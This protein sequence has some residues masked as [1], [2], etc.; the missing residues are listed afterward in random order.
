MADFTL[1]KGQGLSKRLIN[2]KNNKRNSKK[3]IEFAIKNTNLRGLEL[4]KAF[5]KTAP[6]VS[7][8]QLTGKWFINNRYNKKRIDIEYICS[9]GNTL[10]APFMD[11]IRGD[12]KNKCTCKIPGKKDLSIIKNEYFSNLMKTKYKDVYKSIKFNG[13]YLPIDKLTNTIKEIVSSNETSNI[14]LVAPTGA[15]KTY[16]ILNG[17]TELFKILMILPNTM[18]VKQTENTYNNLEIQGLYGDSDYHNGYSSV[19]STPDSI[20]KISNF[21]SF[22]IVFFDETHI[23]AGDYDYRPGA[24]FNAYLKTDSIKHKV[25]VTA[26]P[27][28][29]LYLK[30]FTHIIEFTPLTPKQVQPTINIYDKAMNKDNN[31]IY[32][33]QKEII[34]EINR[35]Y[36]ENK[37]NILGKEHNK[38]IILDMLY[39]NTD[40][41]INNIDVPDNQKSK[42]KSGLKDTSKTHKSIINDSLQ[43]VFALS[44]TDLFSNGANINNKSNY[45]IFIIGNRI[46]PKIV[47]FI[48][49]FRNA[50]SLN[51]HIFSKYH[52]NEK[53]K[54]PMSFE[55]KLNKKMND[56]KKQVNYYNND[57][58]G[59]VKSVQAPNKN[60]LLEYLRLIDNKSNSENKLELSDRKFSY[61][62]YDNQ[63]KLFKINE[64]AVINYI[65]EFYYNLVTKEILNI[66]LK[67]YYQDIKIIKGCK[68]SN[69][70]NNDKLEI[71]ETIK[72]NSLELTY[73]AILDNTYKE[74]N[75][76]LRQDKI[77]QYNKF[78]KEYRRRNI[79]F[80]FLINPKGINQIISS[81]IALDFLRTGKSK[82]SKENILNRKVWKNYRNAIETDMFYTKN[83]IKEIVKR[84]KKEN[85][86]DDSL[87]DIEKRLKSIFYSIPTRAYI[88]KNGNSKQVKGHKHYV[89]NRET[90]LLEMNKYFRKY[91]IEFKEFELYEIITILTKNKVKN[92]VKNR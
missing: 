62:F 30:D 77:I 32:E 28:N 10:R 43:D 33:Y 87:K 75:K 92:K 66:Q 39:Q 16:S 54:I 24:F 7:N 20:D 61:F 78:L 19:V 25:H 81:Y 70:K 5:V 82:V 88:F 34:K 56:V 21:D 60:E 63:S 57:Y 37:N 15:G 4:K 52:E 9:C 31:N 46:A 71:K 3:Y 45:H 50:L 91:N 84:L 38:V 49:R 68:I 35:L 2:L 36:K 86:L 72:D 53:N 27:T 67:E 26:T 48:S 90:I 29:S 42:L 74:N 69:S 13:K 1:N 89:H 11:K 6:F 80:Y 47:Q 23:Y 73:K 76:N 58:D 59:N 83:E 12:L 79:A 65:Y 44:T 22:N 55:Y 51:V 8:I 64:L 18:N 17:F 14:L 85:K 40:I 41:I